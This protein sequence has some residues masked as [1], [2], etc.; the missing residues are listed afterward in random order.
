V[1]AYNSKNYY[2]SGDVAKPGKIPWTG[3]D[4]VADALNYAG[5][6]LNV[7]DRR[8]IRLIRPGCGGKPAKIYKVDW[9]GILERGETETNYQLFPGDRLIVGR[10]SVAT[11]K[12]EIDR[13]ADAMQTVVTSIRL[14]AAMA[15]EITQTANPAASG[16]TS[17]M[18]PEQREAIIKAWADF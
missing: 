12:V 1:T 3:H 13:I 18:T 9:E 10:D 7:G 16:G 8:N 6:L 14:N 11:T 17:T 15:R 4:S 2:V 5:G